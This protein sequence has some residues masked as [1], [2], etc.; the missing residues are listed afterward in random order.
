M[1]HPGFKEQ[2][3]LQ[4]TP[5]NAPHPSPKKVQCGAIRSEQFLNE[6]RLY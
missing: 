6:C 4:P 1:F 3:A 5:P 2:M